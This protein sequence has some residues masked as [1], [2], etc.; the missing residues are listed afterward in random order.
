MLNLVSPFDEYYRRYGARE[1]LIFNQ[2]CILNSMSGVVPDGQ[3]N[4]S[5][6]PQ[7]LT[8]PIAS[9]YMST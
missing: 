1:R 3:S 2:R 6:T 7:S 9:Q 5:A 4:G 8:Q